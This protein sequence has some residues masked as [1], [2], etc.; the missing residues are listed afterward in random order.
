MATGH[1]YLTIFFIKYHC[2]EKYKKLVLLCFVVVCLGQSLAAQS[3]GR[4]HLYGIGSDLAAPR[5]LTSPYRGWLQM[6]PMFFSLG[7]PIENLA[8]ADQD[9]NG[10]VHSETGAALNNKLKARDFVLISFWKE[11]QGAGA[12][13]D[14]T[15]QIR[16]KGAIP[17]LVLPESR[18]QEAVKMSEAGARVIVCHE[19]DNYKTDGYLNAYGAVRTARQVAL[20]LQETFPVLAALK[21][22]Q[23]LVRDTAAGNALKPDDQADHVAATLKLEAALKFRTLTLPDN[24]T[25]WRQSASWLRKRLMELSGV[26]TYHGLDLDMHETGKIQK[27]GYAIHKIYFQTR[28][29]VYAT[30]NLYVPDGSGPF[31]AVI[32][33]HGHW[34]DGKAGE[35]VQACAVSLALNGYV[36]LNIDAWGA[37]ER[38]TTQGEAEYHGAGLGA[39]LMNVGETLLGSQVTDNMR[40]VDLLC[41]LPYVNS[42]LIGATGAS[43]GGNQTMWLSALDTRIKASMPVVSVGTF[44]SYIMG[45][46]CVCE[47]M[48]AGLT[49][50][51]ESGVLSLIAPR[52]IKICNGLLDPSPTFAPAQMLRSYE[53]AK[54]IFALAGCPQNIQYQLLNTPHGY[55]PETRMV[56]LGWFNQRLKGS[57]ADLVVPEKPFTLLP[58]KDLSVFAR[59]NRSRDIATTVSFES[60]QIAK[61][62]SGLLKKSFEKQQTKDD[63]RKLLMLSPFPDSIEKDLHKADV[64]TGKD[65]GWLKG[66]F[67]T[68]NG[69]L[70]AYDYLPPSKPDG[71]ILVVCPPD[72][73]GLEPGEAFPKAYTQR[74]F[75]QLIDRYQGAGDGVLIAMLW[76][77]GK[78]GSA[79]GRQVNGALPLFHTEAR[80]ELWLGRTVMG[81]WVSDLKAI[82]DYLLQKMPDC[83]LDLAAGKELTVSALASAALY[84]DFNQLY[85]YQM[86]LDYTLKNA[87]EADF[88]NM[89]IHLPHYLNF[90]GAS[91]LAALADKTK[92]TFYAPLTLGG[93]ALSVDRKNKFMQLYHHFAK[94]MRTYNTLLF[95]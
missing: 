41:S 92:I 64:K 42:N 5:E 75:Q 78:E 86:P 53:N 73:A 18:G 62:E 16:Q 3:A 56:M 15:E 19:E 43:G 90:G 12:L 77:L 45:S 80:A 37:G 84:G 24:E 66:Q 6:L 61:I 55:F 44:Q 54:K 29:G 2:R 49:C 93:E 33:M 34:P 14:L 83:H 4:P 17:V 58:A 26:K 65:Q 40:G 10:F 22:G 85:L 74:Y 91:M 11:A 57:G 76:D 25:K 8:K 13:S 32:N 71:R 88:F 1:T 9:I 31:P 46:N 87:G 72:S 39:S 89:A 94:V 52:S 68:K 30:A 95:N 59:G 63:L 51:E 38:T 50:T 79:T 67:M 69:H 81:E 27:E 23:G 48:P 82:K 7:T 20:K 28:P 47:L 36:C 60:R 35:M 70:L 21:S